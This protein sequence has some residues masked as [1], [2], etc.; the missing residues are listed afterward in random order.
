M[1]IGLITDSLA[2]LPTDEQIKTARNLGLDCL[3]FTT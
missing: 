1:K 3:E 2:N